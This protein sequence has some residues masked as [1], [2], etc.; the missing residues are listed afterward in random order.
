MVSQEQYNEASKQAPGFSN[1]GLIPV[2]MSHMSKTLYK[3]EVFL[4][5]ARAQK[6]MVSYVSKPYTNVE[7]N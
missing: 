2:Y 1:D 7:I 4:I 3:S 6:N 5:N